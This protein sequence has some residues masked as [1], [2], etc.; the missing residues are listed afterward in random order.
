MDKVLQFELTDGDYVMA[1]GNQPSIPPK[2]HPDYVWMPNTPYKPE[3]PMESDTLV[4]YF[5]S[6]HEASSTRLQVLGR[7]PKRRGDLVGKGGRELGWGLEFVDG[8]SIVGFGTVTLLG[9]IGAI[10]VAIVTKHI[11]GDT[12]SAVGFA[13]LVLSLTGLFL[14]FSGFVIS[15]RATNDRRIRF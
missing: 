11:K 2:D 4:R 9:V 10:T 1:S 12:G 8:V 3:L 6:P 7:L 14:S 13:G 5:Y 15:R